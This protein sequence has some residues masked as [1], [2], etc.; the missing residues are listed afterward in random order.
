MK[1]T[2]ILALVLLPATSGCEQREKSLA[3]ICREAAR[4]EVRD[5][6]GWNTYLEKV[7]ATVS[8]NRKLAAKSWL[9]ER[10]IP[11]PP[12]QIYLIPF[13][14]VEGYEVV[15]Q[16]P[17]F[18]NTPGAGET[19]GPNDQLVTGAGKQIATIHDFDIKLTHFGYTDTGSC[20]RDHPEVYGL[21]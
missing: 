7:R 2:A 1:I 9:A 13:P 6:Q 21:R 18:S 14:Y 3:Q 11:Q 16:H 19:P 20:T 17:R 4:I 8:E 12:V 15:W 5:T 10:N